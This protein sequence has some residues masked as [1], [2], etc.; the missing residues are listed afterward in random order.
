M[1]GVN[2]G[3]IIQNYVSRQNDET[4]MLKRAVGYRYRVGLPSSEETKTCLIVNVACDA[5]GNVVCHIVSVIAGNEITLR[6]HSIVAL[7]VEI[8]PE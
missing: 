5:R 2:T 3:V 4:C 7:L 6:R 1:Y 8:T